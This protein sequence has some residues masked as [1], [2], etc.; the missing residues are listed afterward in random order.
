MMTRWEFLVAQGPEVLAGFLYRTYGAVC[1]AC[2]YKTGDGRC[3]GDC[4]TGMKLWWQ[5]EATRKF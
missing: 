5:E 2:H 4:L 1:N 3:R